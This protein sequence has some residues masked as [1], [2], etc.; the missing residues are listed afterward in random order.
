MEKQ[1]EENRR[2]VFLSLHNQSFGNSVKPFRGDMIYLNQFTWGSNITQFAT[3][4][5]LPP[6]FFEVGI[7]LPQK[8]AQN[9]DVQALL[10]ALSPALLLLQR[11]SAPPEN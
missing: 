4:Q 6:F 9:K 1:M 8:T 5:I 11:H 10:L 2:Q 3:L 7:P